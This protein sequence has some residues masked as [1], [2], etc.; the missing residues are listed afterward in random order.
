VDWYG[1]SASVSPYILEQFEQ[2]AGYPFRPE[3]IIDQGYY[4]GQY[5]IPSKEYQDFQAFKLFVLDVGLLGAMTKLSAKV[6]L[7][8]NALFEEFK[9]ALT[10]QYVLQQLVLNPEHDIFYWSS[11][12]AKAELDFL[13]QND[14]KIIPM[15]VKAEENLQA[16]SLKMFYQ[17]YQ[18]DTAVRTSMSDYRIQDWMVNIPLYGIGQMFSALCEGEG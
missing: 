16:K 4:N 7:E 17:K 6:I 15:E 11:D 3:Y 8:G 18:P 13:I 5:R 1:Y 14:D 9:G 12:T 10:E 2:E